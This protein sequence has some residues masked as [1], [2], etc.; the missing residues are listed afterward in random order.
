MAIGRALIKNPGFCFADEPTSALDWAHGEQVV[1]LLR[2]AAHER[3]ATILVVAHDARIIP[4]VDRVF[5]LE[6]GSCS[7]PREASTMGITAKPLP[8]CRACANGRA[9]TGHWRALKEMDRMKSTPKYATPVARRRLP[10]FWILGVALLAISAIGSGVALRSQNGTYQAKEAAAAERVEQGPPVVATGYVDSKREIRSLLPTQSGAWSRIMVTEGQHVDKGAVLL[11]IDD[12]VAQRDVQ[13]A[14]ANYD[15]ALEQVKVADEAAHRYPLQIQEQ[16]ESI[17][18]AQHSY[19]AAL[20]AKNR[21]M[22]LADQN[23]ANV[24]QAKA[25]EEKANGDSRTRWPP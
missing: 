23:L 25:E 22:T 7:T 21:A 2:A 19:L 16:E 10:I 8:G 11:E 1:E 12:Y 14:K 15:A 20:H 3:G 13:K 6:D 4:Y 24:D 9:L 5:H 17:K 18:A